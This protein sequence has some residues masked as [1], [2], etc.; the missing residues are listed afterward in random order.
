MLDVK[1]DKQSVLNQWAD[2]LAVVWVGVSVVVVAI[3]FPNSAIA[4][5][6]EF[7]CNR[8]VPL[9][10]QNSVLPGL[11]RSMPYSEAREISIDRGWQAQVPASMS[12]YP[13][14]EN[15][16]IG[17]LFLEREYQKVVDC[18]GTGLGICRFEVRNTQGERLV[19]ITANNQPGQA[20]SVFSWFFE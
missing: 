15:P 10:S 7:D 19:V 9:D 13:N 2:T 4:N 11:K 8:R 14:L 6:N 18:A 1:Q 20:I 17:Y 5:E 12:P 3:G 16:T